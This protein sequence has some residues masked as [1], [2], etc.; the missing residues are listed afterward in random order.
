MNLHSTSVGVADKKQACKLCKLEG[1]WP[2]VGRGVEASS[3][4]KGYGSKKMAFEGKE[5]KDGLGGL[6]RKS[7]PENKKWMQV[8]DMKTWFKAIEPQGEESQMDQSKNRGVAGAGLR[9][10]ARDPSR[11]ALWGV[12]EKRDFILNEVDTSGEFW[13]ECN[14]TSVLDHLSYGVGK[15]WE[16]KGEKE[17]T[18]SGAG[19]PRPGGWCCLSLAVMESMPVVW[20]D[21]PL[22]IALF[23]SL[24]NPHSL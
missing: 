14:L 19:F 4:R 10:E 21:V 5:R 20:T 2:G 22:W 23:S 7:I 24:L 12:V 13:M 1:A 11:R 16:S 6:W 18:G 17:E 15:K 9:E 8:G 3:A